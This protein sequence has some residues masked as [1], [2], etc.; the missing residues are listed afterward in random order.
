MHAN[1]SLYAVRVRGPGETSQGAMKNLEGVL[2]GQS[3]D[4]ARQPG[5]LPG[6]RIL[7]QEPPVHAAGNFR[8]G[9][10]QSFFSSRLVAGFQG[11]GDPLLKGPHA[12]ALVPVNFGAPGGLANALLRLFRV[13]H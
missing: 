9:G 11:Q 8:L 2:G 10:L 4:A 13:G 5:N 6:S 12:A 1:R 7:V 3:L